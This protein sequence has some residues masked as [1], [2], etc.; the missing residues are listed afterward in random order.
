[1][2]T[3]YE[4]ELQ[5][6]F[7]SVIGYVFLA[8]FILISSYYFLV[9]NL[10]TRNGDISDWFQ[11]IVQI[12]IF[13]MPLLTMRSFSEEK[14]QKTDVLLYTK[15]IRSGEIVLGKFLAAMTV[16][17]AGLAVTAAFPLILAHFGSSQPLLTCGCYLGLILL[18]G[19]FIAIG[20][21]VSSLTENQIVAAVGTYLIIFIMWYSYGFGSTIQNQA[22]L[23]LLNRISLMNLYYELV[24][25]ILNPAGLTTMLSV[26]AVFLFLTCIA[27]NSRRR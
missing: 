17:A 23:K 21:F 25:G 14:R 20:I 7:H 10:L 26:I 18:M 4:K 22:V 2:K 19:S 5:Q 8:I 24:M 1:M 15:A 11:S 9:T 16:F 6:Y 27:A 12:L 13:L 3:I